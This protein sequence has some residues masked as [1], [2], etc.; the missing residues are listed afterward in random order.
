ML[1]A[2]SFGGADE[3]ADVLATGLVEAGAELVIKPLK[4]LDLP[5]QALYQQFEEAGA[6]TRALAHLQRGPE[7]GRWLSRGQAHDH[8]CLLVWGCC[9]AWFALRKGLAVAEGPSLLANAT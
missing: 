6:P 8:Q 9:G 7:G 3:P 5:Q 2:E 1:V 4:V